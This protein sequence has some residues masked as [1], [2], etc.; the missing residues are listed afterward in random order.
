MT[1]LPD[2]L[3]KRFKDAQLRNT[4]N[5]AMQKGYAMTIEHVFDDYWMPRVFI[6]LYTP[7]KKFYQLWYET[8]W[9][10]GDGW[11]DSAKWWYG[12]L[13]ESEEH[14]DVLGGE[15]DIKQAIVNCKCHSERNND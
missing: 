1:K 10:D 11:G 7:Q 8:K 14:I 5:E 6:Y 3:E 13:K 2:F 4:L 9:G 15:R 12:E